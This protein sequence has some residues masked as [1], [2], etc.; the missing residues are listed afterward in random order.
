MTPLTPPRATADGW[1]ERWRERWCDWR[2]RRVADPAFQRRAAA[3]WFT[4]PVVRRQAGE[5]FDLMAGFV[6]TQ[7]LLSCVRLQLFDLLARGPLPVARIAA[8]TGLD[9]A[10]AQRLC[11][12][13]AA[14]EL[15]DLRADGGYALGRLGAPA[16]GQ[17]CAARDDRTPRHA[18][19]RPG[20]PGGAVARHQRSRRWPAIGPT[21]RWMPRRRHARC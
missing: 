13:A 16:G 5:L 17:R 21:P 12:A 8:A 20:R 2:N 9:I 19:R 3:S 18:V 11:A 7:V 14:L 6:Y 15:L 10:M 1:R 4:R